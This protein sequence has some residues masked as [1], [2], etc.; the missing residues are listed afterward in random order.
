MN[1][2][3]IITLL[4]SILFISYLIYYVKNIEEDK[5]EIEK[6]VQNIINDKMTKFEGE[7]T[8]TKTNLIIKYI[9]PPTNQFIVLNNTYYKYDNKDACSFVIGQKKLINITLIDSINLI[10]KAYDLNMASDDEYNECE[11]HII[12]DTTLMVTYVGNEANIYVKKIKPKWNETPILYQ[13]FKG[14]WQCDSFGDG[15]AKVIIEYKDK[16]FQ[17]VSSS[18]KNIFYNG[19]VFLKNLYLLS[20]TT[21]QKM[22]NADQVYENAQSYFS[23]QV[24]FETNNKSFVIIS[25]GIKQHLDRFYKIK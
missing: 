14:K 22:Y 19:Q 21:F 20:D 7:W 25:D 13:N 5:K 24:S 16:W 11:I 2:P 15:G 3:T 4:I 1:K 6:S 10:Y 17:I 12:N 18:K 9:K 8:H 23:C